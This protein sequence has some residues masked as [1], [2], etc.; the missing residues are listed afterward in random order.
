GVL[1]ELEQEA[2]EILRR[3]T[4]GRAY[5]RIEPLREKG[6]KVKET[7]D[8][9]ISDE[10]GTR[11]YEMFSGGEAFRVDFALRVALSKLLAKRAGTRLRTLVVDEGFGTQDSEGLELLVEA[12]NAISEDFDKI[13]VVTHLEQLRN[14]FPVRIEVEKR[15]DVGSTFQ[16]IGV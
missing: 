7:L 11:D 13:L 3:L 12:I 15:P 8:I 1:P 4:E 16:V 5:V 2:N 14:A 6:G 10:L 9:K